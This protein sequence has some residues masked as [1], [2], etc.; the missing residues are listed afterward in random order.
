MLF[1]DV[2]DEGG[3]RD[4]DGG[5]GDPEGS[6]LADAGVLGLDLVGLYIDDVVLLQIVVGRREEVGIVEVDLVDLLVALGVLTDELY[7]LTDTVDGEVASLG[8]GLED[9]D[10]LTGY[11]ETTGTVYFTEDRDGVAGHLDRDHGV[12]SGIE[13]GLDLVV[14][15]GLALSLSE[16]SDLDATQDGIVD[17]T[18]IV[19]EVGLEDCL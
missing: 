4:E 14:D 19:D 7:I 13:V 3:D 10:L 11:L 1:E 16:A 15:H 9:V 12:L 2:D 8:E 5:G 17:G 18:F 6:G